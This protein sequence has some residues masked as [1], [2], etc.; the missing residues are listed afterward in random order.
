MNGKLKFGSLL[1]VYYIAACISASLYGALKPEDIYDAIQSSTLTLDV[2]TTNG[3]RFLG[4]A[5]LAV[6]QGLA[7]TAWHVVHDAQRVEARFSD[8][9]RVPVAG[10]VDK[11]EELDLALIKL[12]AGNRPSISLAPSTPRIGC[13]VFII[14]AP[15]GLDFS[16]SDG[17]LSQIRTFNSVRYYQVSCPISPGDSGGPVLNENAEVVGVMS[18]RKG[19]AQN[20][21]FATPSSNIARLNSSRP[22]V[23]WDLLLSQAK[24]SPKS[25]RPVENVSSE[26]L[27][28][29]PLPPDGYREFQRFLAQ[30]A[31]KRL[32]IS[33]SGP[34]T[35]PGS[36]EFVM[37]PQ[38]GASQG[39][40]ED[41]AG[42]E[43][44][45]AR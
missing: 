11:N 26:S 21:A 7:V 12:E 1:G 33:V 6:G 37:P 22:L 16:I 25:A 3:D 14:G 30:A 34:G 42:S 4:S 28:R 18:W 39:A 19:N 17:L 5:F 9:Q 29:A 40:P 41:R 43:A 10:L 2:Q 23:P 44:P 15:R 24:P 20:V 36:F 35:P 45:P 8:N 13:R 38:R 27:A 32:S 31:G